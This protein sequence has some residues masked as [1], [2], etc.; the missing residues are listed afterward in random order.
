MVPSTLCVKLQNRSILVHWID[1]YQNTNLLIYSLL[2]IMS[3]EQ[4]NNGSEKQLEFSL[5]RVF[6]S[7]NYWNKR[8]DLPKV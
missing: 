3:T 8:M 1:R 4:N 7:F 5:K 2:K 6:L